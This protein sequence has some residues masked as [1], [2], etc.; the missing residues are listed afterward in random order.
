MPP[1]NAPDDSATILVVDDHH[2]NVL[3]MEA[4]LES[5]GYTIVTA[6]SGPEAIDIVRAREA[7]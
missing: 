3:A 2:G 4:A 5:L 1:T 7:R 6:S